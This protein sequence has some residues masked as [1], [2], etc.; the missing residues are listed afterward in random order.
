M[1]KCFDSYQDIFGSVTF[2]YLVDPILNNGRFTSWTFSILILS[3]HL[4]MEDADSEGFGVGLSI[5]RAEVTEGVK[6][7]SG[8]R[9][10]GGVQ[11]KP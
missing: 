11:D 5:T 8:S 3:A 2:V 4:S 6:K 9:A 1:L 10:P 7:L